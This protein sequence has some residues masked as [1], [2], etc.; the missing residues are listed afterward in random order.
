[1]L[2]LDAKNEILGRLAAKIAKLLIQGEKIEVTNINEIKQTSLDK[3]YWRYTGFPGGIKKKTYDQ[4]DAGWA[5]KKAV[6]G[7]LP[8]NKLQKIRIKNLIIK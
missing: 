2:K 8:K 4:I 5:F 7:M 3:V 1:M 6:K